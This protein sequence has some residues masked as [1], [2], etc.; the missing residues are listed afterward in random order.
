M[1]DQSPYPQILLPIEGE[2]VFVRRE[3]I[4]YLE[5]QGS[6]SE[7]HLLDGRRSRISKKLKSALEILGSEDFVRIHH[8]YLINLSHLSSLKGGE[9]ASVALC[10]GIELPVS[11]SKKADFF[12]LFRRL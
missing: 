4:V 2:Q 11:R 12:N 5:A 6:Y 8:S 9:H 1:P 10:N 3:D 7:V